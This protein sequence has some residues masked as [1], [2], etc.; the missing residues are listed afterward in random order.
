[1]NDNAPAKKQRMSEH[2]Q[3]T[4]LS[5]YFAVIREIPQT[6]HLQFRLKAT[7]SGLEVEAKNFIFKINIPTVNAAV[8]INEVFIFK[9]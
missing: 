8:S 2:I 5:S 6:A 7:R 9:C 3:G 4:R 1:M